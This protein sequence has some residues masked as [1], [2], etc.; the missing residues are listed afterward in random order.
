MSPN[1]HET[2][3]A[4]W[5]QNELK[6]GHAYLAV[7][8]R[9]SQ[10]LIATAVM[11]LIG[12]STEAS[13]SVSVPDAVLIGGTQPLVVG[14]SFPLTAT[15][16]AKGAVV[17]GPVVW[18]SSNPSVAAISSSGLVRAFARGTTTLSATSGPVS[19]TAALSVIGVRS[20]I[21]TPETVDVPI[22]VSSTLRTLVDA[23]AGV[24]APVTWFSRNPNI[25]TVSAA[26]AVTGVALGTAIITATARGTEGASVVTV[27]PPPPAIA[28]IN[29]A[30]L[31]LRTGQ[32][33]QLGTNWVIRA[34][35]SVSVTYSYRSSHE[36]F[37]RVSSSGLATGVSSGF[38]IL[39]L[40]AIGTGIGVTP[41]TVT[42][43]VQVSVSP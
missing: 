37:A 26:G 30:P 12:C 41:T 27:T 7:R 36:W 8:Q 2:P 14:D 23:D 3:T 29:L 19:S 1:T 35:S 28:A 17:A 38:A 32:T 34:N 33:I 18:T 42:R 20:V 16:T 24:S 10:M 39:T 43:T 6:K 21:V 31:S 5:R 22:G 9:V 40:T 4:S 13:V 11:L 25:A 15:V